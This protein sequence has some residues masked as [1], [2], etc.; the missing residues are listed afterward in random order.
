MNRRNIVAAA[1]L[2][3]ILAAA[4]VPALGAS[5]PKKTINVIDDSFAPPK[6]T[7]KK[8]TI[9]VWKWSANNYEEHNVKLVSAPHGVKKFTSPSGTT[10]ITFRKR[11]TK[12]GTYKF[13]CTYHSSVMKLTLRV[14]R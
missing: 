2:G 10:G 13:V 9:V 11:F 6:A 12:P 4:A 5:T 1:A 14:K 3:G 8:N 7:V